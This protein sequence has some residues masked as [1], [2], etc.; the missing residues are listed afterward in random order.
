MTRLVT[1]EVRYKD[2]HITYH[3]LEGKG[4]RIDPIVRCL[5]IGRGT[6]RHMV[7]L[8]NVRLF[9]FSVTHTDDQSSRAQN[10]ED[11]IRVTTGGR[12]PKPSD[13]PLTHTPLGTYVG[14]VGTGDYRLVQPGDS[15]VWRT[16]TQVTDR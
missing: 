14:T 4:W 5:V 7:P 1:L 8:D 10:L 15:V 2:D 12:T 13:M 6:D 16:Q 9:S 11:H 3:K